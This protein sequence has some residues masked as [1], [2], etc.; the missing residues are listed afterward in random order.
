M[1]G[2]PTANSKDDERAPSA[3][4]ELP[5]L[6]VEGRNLI[7]TS[8]YE[9]P[10]AERPTHDTI[11]GISRW[12]SGD[13]RRVNS[14]IHTFDELGWRLLAAGLPLLRVSVHSATLHPQFR[15][16]TC[17]WWR[18][19]GKSQKVMIAHEIGELI[20]Y[21]DNPV[22]RVQEGRETLRRR[23]DGPEAL[24]D[25]AV[26]SELKARGATDYLALP[27]ESDFGFRAHMAAFF[28]DRPGGFLDS[29]AADLTELSPHLAVIADM[30]NQRQIAEN[31]LRA[32][33]GPQTGP[34]VLAGQIRRGSGESITAIIWSSDLRG[35]TALSDQLPSERVI[36]ILN[37][38]F[39]LQAKTIAANGGEILKFIGD[40]LLAIFPVADPAGAARAAA[41]ALAA[42]RDTL[43][44]LSKAQPL[45]EEAPPKI[46]IALH[47]GAVIYGNIGSADRLDFTVIGPAVNLVSR[48]ES[49]AKSLDLPLVVSD[50]FA[51]VYGQGLP[52]LGRHKL[53]GLEQPHELF[54]PLGAP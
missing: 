45:G 42:A 50:D 5:S 31:V 8:V 25:F 15:S 44:E 40:G 6:L 4:P 24:L 51:E 49:I 20:P 34:R 12:L 9:R 3:G 47:Y 39:D 1:A 41:S 33:L 17:T 36:A 2:H 7:T 29:E 48:I 53:R 54:A 43:A 30:T 37:D 27:V 10:V 19:T 32:Y 46:V 26:L 13:A 28:S 21:S 16:S 52:S 23:L 35:F 38:L 14:M 22:R 18:D 11:V